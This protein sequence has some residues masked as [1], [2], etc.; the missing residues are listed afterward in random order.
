[1]YGAEMNYGAI[2]EF[3]GSLDTKF[4]PM[5]YF[6]DGLYIVRIVSATNVRTYNIIKQ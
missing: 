4:V 3:D 5:S 6:P 1:M 2:I